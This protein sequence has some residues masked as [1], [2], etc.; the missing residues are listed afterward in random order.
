MSNT[1]RMA[2]IAL[3]A[4]CIAVPLLLFSSGAIE[5]VSD[6]MLPLA[7]TYLISDDVMALAV[8]EGDPQIRY[9]ASTGRWQ[10]YLFGSWQDISANTEFSNFLDAYDV[11][12]LADIQAASLTIPNLLESYTRYFGSF[13]F[14]YNRR[15]HLGDG[16]Q[17]VSVSSFAQLLSTMGNDWSGYFTAGGPV[18]Y[19]GING[20]MVD[21]PSNLG[22]AWLNRA[23][24]A[25][26]HTNL[27]GNGFQ[28]MIN[29]SGNTVTVS[30]LLSGLNA[31]NNNLYYSYVLSGSSQYLA[32]D[33]SIQ[34]G[35]NL[36]VPY[37]IEEGF[38]G[39]WS[40]IHG[41]ASR[42]GDLKFLN[43]SDLSPEDVITNDNLFSLLA[44]GFNRL[45]NDF[46]YYL[47]S[48]GTDMDIEIRHNMQDQA[49]AFVDEF[50]SPGGSGT[51]STSDIKDTA[52]VS[53]GI[54]DA[55]SGSSTPAD[56]FGQLSDSGN[57]SFLSPETQAELNPFY[58]TRLYRDD[59]YVDFVTPQL[60]AIFGGLGRKW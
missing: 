3:C 37:L 5:D 14:N 28:F 20:T 23:G 41:A 32:G 13:P 44:G 12:T 1:R 56:A 26:L 2:F 51:P 10:T 42:E 34:D 60:E 4:T 25:G 31:L 33:G 50:T 7:D 17:S 59:G 45:Q 53:K 49:D 19:L 15:A 52:G 43:Y 36:K 24:F 18:T 39:V 35:T 22:L 47:Y 30:D 29:P 21:Y 16:Y 58:N 40:V 27:V 57:Y 46:A 6:L 11:A 54:S 9:N 38:S 8:G 55:F 48:H